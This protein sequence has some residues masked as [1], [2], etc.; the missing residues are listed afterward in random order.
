MLQGI[1]DRHAIVVFPWLTVDA[2]IVAFAVLSPRLI[3][4]EFTTVQFARGL[5]STPEAFRREPK[6][7]IHILLRPL[8]NGLS[9]LSDAHGVVEVDGGQSHDAIRDGSQDAFKYAIEYSDLVVLKLLIAHVQI[10]KLKHERAEALK[11]AQDTIKEGK[12]DNHV[13]EPGEFH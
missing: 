2:R 8:L 1:D 3:A 11:E 10:S 7:L 9:L 4:L 5:P 6:F 13:V 12:S